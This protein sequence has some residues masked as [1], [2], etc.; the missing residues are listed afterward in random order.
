HRLREL[1]RRRYRRRSVL[2]ATLA[3]SL[4]AFL[5]V[6]DALG[7]QRAARFEAEHSGDPVASLRQWQSYQLWHPTRH[8]LRSSST[9]AEEQHLLD[10]QLAELRQQA[11]DPD[12]EPETAWQHFQ[13]LRANYPEVTG[14]GE[15][16]PLRNTLKSRRDEQIRRRAQLAFDQ[17]LR[18][19]QES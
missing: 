19:E 4:V 2:A 18:A 6:Y 1:R 5:W 12:A 8:W 3:A 11:K 10:L 9:R 14:A 7:H 13:E 15:L 16:E 17:L